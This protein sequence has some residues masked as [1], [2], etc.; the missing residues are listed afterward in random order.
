MKT[1]V[2]TGSTRGIGFALATVIFKKR[3]QGSHQRSQTEFGGCCG[4]TPE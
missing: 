3:M 2:I 4:G 1:I